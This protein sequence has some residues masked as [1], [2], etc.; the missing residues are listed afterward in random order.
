MVRSF[1][2]IQ[3]NIRKN[4]PSSMDFINKTLLWYLIWPDVKFVFEQ[5]ELSLPEELQ[6]HQNLKLESM[7]LQEH[8]ILVFLKGYTNSTKSKIEIHTIVFKKK[9]NQIKTTNHRKKELVKLLVLD[10][11]SKQFQS[12]PLSPSLKPRHSNPSSFIMYVINSNMTILNRE[13]SMKV[14]V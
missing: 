8:K 6:Q 12:D 11:V 3:Q 9:A 10:W 4:V 2:F 5:D 14:R 7:I 13:K 1:Q